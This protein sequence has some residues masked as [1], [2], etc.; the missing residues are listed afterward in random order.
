MADRT[1]EE[2]EAEI[3]KLEDAKKSEQSGMKKM[4]FAG[5][6]KDLGEREVEVVITTDQEDRDKDIVEPKGI[7]LAAYNKNPVVLFQHSAA[8]PVARTVKLDV[9]GD[10]LIARA[11]FVRTGVSQKADEVYGLIQDGIINAASIGFLPKV[12]EPRNRDAPWGGQLFKE[13]ELLEW[14]FVSIPSNSGALIIGRSLGQE[15]GKFYSWA[16]EAGLAFGQMK[17]LTEEEVH[18]EIWKFEGE[19]WSKT[20]ECQMFPAAEAAT[21]LSPFKG[22]EIEEE[23]NENSPCTD[24]EDAC[25]AK[26]ARLRAC[27]ALRLRT[28]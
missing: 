2:A 25:I 21:A 5:V 22:F 23:K 8:M 11:K 1:L 26:A 27:D 20:E 10:R 6:T 28:N 19:V 14:S 24:D 17:S 16:G 3:K 18:L 15:V 12:W 4:A 7:G 9:Y 13:T